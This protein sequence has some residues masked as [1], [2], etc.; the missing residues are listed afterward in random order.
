MV[1]KGKNEIKE[2]QAD[3]QAKTSL[4]LEQAKQSSDKI[5]QLES[6]LQK[7]VSA[8]SLAE[9]KLTELEEQLFLEKEKGTQNDE[10]LSRLKAVSEE[11]RMKI[12]EMDASLNELQDEMK[13][14]Q[15]QLFELSG[16][17]Y[18]LQQKLEAKQR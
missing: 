9:T 1:E 8:L 11:Y 6:Q 13:V 18:S 2:L 7:K 10:G 4:S 15:E 14:K 5:F 12:H 17:N 16:K 3:L